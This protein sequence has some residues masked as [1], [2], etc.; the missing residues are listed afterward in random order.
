[1]SAAAAKRPWWIPPFLGR[2]PPL[3]DRHIKLLGV[4]SLALLF[5]G[6][7]LSII[8]SA[9]KHI[10]EGVGMDEDK[11]GGLLGLVR[12]GGLPALAVVPVADRIGRRPVFLATVVGF[13][14]G[15]FLTALAQTPAH[16]VAAQM[17]TRTFLLAGVAIGMVLIAEEFPAEH[18]GWGIGMTAALAAFG[19]G[20]GALGFA[21][22]DLLPFGWRSLYAMGILPVLLIPMF[23]RNLP[24]TGRF[25]AH[26]LATGKASTADTGH[27]W[28][29][30]LQ[31]VIDLATAFPGR[32]ALVGLTALLVAT[33]EVSVFQFTSYIVQKLHG[34]SPGQYSFMVIAGGM[35][36]IIGNIVAG[37]QG[38]KHGRRIVGAVFFLLYPAAAWLF[39]R[40]PG[41]AA[42]PIAYIFIVFCG[43]AGSVILRAIST[44]LFPTSFRSTASGWTVSVQTLGWAL[45]LWLLGM[46]SDNAEQIASATAW[47]S[48]TVAVGGLVLLR[49]PETRGRELE[50]ISRLD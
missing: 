46:G 49:L 4:V 40:G 19:H 31:P 48:L 30:A 13:S 27:R 35:I 25:I 16:F 41:G 10:A 21:F 23:R 14:V 39:Y 43:T 33:G 2:L 29:D 47:I 12:I 44:E 34:W 7:D 36:G 26:Q 38:D 11:M 28:R 45:G 6:Y 5:E 24:E 20:L 42:L 50:D 37:K 8:T 17:F 22:I 9:L 32:T 3:E 18:R 15:T 1:M